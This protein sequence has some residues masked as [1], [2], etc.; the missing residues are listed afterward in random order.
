MPDVLTPSQRRL[1]MSRIRGKNTKPEVKLRSALHHAGMRF[2]L[3]VRGLPGTPDLVFPGR[4]IAVFVHGCFWHMHGCY[5][6]VAP[7]S[8]REFWSAKLRVNRVR[9]ERARE[10]LLSDGWRVLTVWEC[11]IIGRT[12]VPVSDLVQDVGKWMDSAERSGHISGLEC[13]AIG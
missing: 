13:S 8:R 1:N 12:A 4:R 10:L 3:H 7:K 11:A 6:T 9:D 5:R 2:R